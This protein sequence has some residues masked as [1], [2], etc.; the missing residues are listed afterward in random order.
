MAD[1]RLVPADPEMVAKYHE[2]G[3]PKTCRA[4]AATDGERILG[5]AGLY[6]TDEHQIVFSTISEELKKHPRVILRAAKRLLGMTRQGVPVIAVPDAGIAKSRGFL[7][8]LGFAELP[9]TGVYEWQR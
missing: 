6:F 5:I 8:H 9:G 1:I 2:E 4:I 7:E 3:L